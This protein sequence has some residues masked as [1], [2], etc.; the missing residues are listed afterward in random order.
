MAFYPIAN[1]LNR[2]EF[3]MEINTCECKEKNTLRRTTIRHTLCSDLVNKFNNVTCTSLI[4]RALVRLIGYIIG[5]FTHSLLITLTHRLC[6]AI[7]RLHQLEFIVAHALGFLVSTSHF[8]ATVLYTQATTVLQSKYYTRRNSSS[9]T[10][11][12]LTA[13]NFSLLLQFTCN[14]HLPGNAW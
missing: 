3:R 1:L 11:S 6:S 2:N 10:L 4:R 7:S 14:S 9:H 8:P 12:L 5:W 13:T